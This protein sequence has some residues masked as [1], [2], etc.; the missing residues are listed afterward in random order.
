MIRKLRL[1]FIAIIALIMSVILVVE[2]VCINVVTRKIGMMQ[3]ESTLSRIAASVQFENI[4][5]VPDKPDGQD[6][7]QNDRGRVYSQNN[8][9]DKS[10]E[11]NFLSN[12]ENNGEWE[13]VPDDDYKK[14]DGNADLK[15]ERYYGPYEYGDFGRPDDEWNFDRW[16]YD[17][18]PYDRPDNNAPT[19]K[20]IE[21]TKENS[22]KPTVTTARRQTNPKTTTVVKN[23][24]TTD[25]KTENNNRS[26][27]TTVKRQTNSKTTTA[28]KNQKP[29]DKKTGN[30][31]PIATT[32][33][34][35]ADFKV[36]TAIINPNPNNEKIE[37]DIPEKIETGANAET[38]KINQDI[39]NNS[40]TTEVTEESTETS[41]S[42]SIIDGEITEENSEKSPPP[43]DDKMPKLDFN[44]NRNSVTVDYFAIVLDKSKEIHRVTNLKDTDSLTDKQ[45]EYL[46]YTA[47]NSDKVSAIVNN[48]QYYKAEKSYGYVLVYTNKSSENALMRKMLMISILVTVAAMLVL[49]GI[50]VILSNWTVKPVKEAFVKQKQFISDAS[51]EL[52]TPLTVISANADL[53][54]EEIG[55]N[56]W[57]GYIKGQTERMRTLVYELLDLSRMDAAKEPEKVFTEFS[58]SEAVT[59]AALPFESSAFEQNKNLQIN[60]QDGILYTGNEKQIKQLTAI[61]IDNAIKYSNEKGNIIVTLRKEKE[62]PVLEFFNTGCTIKDD[63]REKI[64]ERFYRSD[65]S[66]ARQTGGY[67]L[68]LAIAKS[69]MDSHKMKISVNSIEN[70]WIRFTI[71]L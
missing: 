24:K 45:L 34:P 52:K 4:D 30:N 17:R 58:L 10:A 61:F 26:V 63:E 15:D 29:T 27:V 19:E 57:L 55:E 25:K 3:T 70:A 38:E 71:N 47:L 9:S 5:G 64:F 12:I 54:E 49:L 22:N 59:N 67:G 32:A 48:Y 13:Y 39:V 11:I 51:H 65:S 20:Y 40:E 18:P 36:T 44:D 6:D 69:I 46:A 43:P 41:E 62:R 56:K 1:K 2:I 35:Q 31:K 8:F 33:K 14:A 7:S 21:P 60:I 50:A 37:N 68:G 16:D 23:Q 53:L 42:T 66:R 28:V